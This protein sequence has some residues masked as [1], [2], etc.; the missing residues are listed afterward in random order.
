MERYLLDDIILYFLGDRRG[1]IVKYV[2]TCSWTSSSGDNNRQ[3]TRKGQATG[4]A[5]G[6][7]SGE[8]IPMT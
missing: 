8:P 1:V 5:L 3:Q 6:M 7:I 2:K 4:R